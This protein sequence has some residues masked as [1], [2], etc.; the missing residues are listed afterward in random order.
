MTRHQNPHPLNNNQF[1]AFIPKHILLMKVGPYCN[2]DLESIIR[3]KLQEEKMV[4]K[5][6]WG[7]GGVFCR[8]HSI[9]AFV[10]HASTEDSVPYVLF[11]E[12]KSAYTT[13]NQGKFNEF[14]TDKATWHPLPKGVTLVGNSQKPHF[15]VVCNELAQVNFEIDLSQYIAF[16]GG[17][18]DP[19]SLLKRYF[20]YRVDKACGY[21]FPS[22]VSFHKES[23]HW[24]KVNYLA[25]LVAPYGVFI[26]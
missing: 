15:A 16:K 14:S 20:R 18:P 5:F 17:V 24:I 11:V 21:L 3:I 2:Y 19:N 9:Q 26:R 12:T 4:G 25:K 8:P 10:S 7:F 1:D 13:S 23:S 6:F 22:A